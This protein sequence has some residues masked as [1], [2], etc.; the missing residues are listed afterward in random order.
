MRGVPVCLFLHNDPRG[1]R[2]ARSAVERGRL[3]GAL[4]GV[5]TVSGYLRGRLLEGVAAPARAVAV[6]PNCL[7]L[8]A[9]PAAAK[10]DLILFAGRVVADKGA[11]SFVAACG[12]ALPGLPGW[13]AAM[14]G[15]DRFGADSPET[16]WIA[17]LRPKAA[18][19]GVVMEG[20]RPHAEVLAAMARA[21]IVVVPS[22]WEEPFGLTALEAMACGAALVA[23][24]RGGLREVYGEAAVV[25][26]PED[27]AGMA[28]VLVALA[29]DPARRAAL[30]AAGRARAAGFDAAP[31]LARLDELRSDVLAAWPRAPAHPI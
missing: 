21:A 11:D 29:R 13:R 16:A 19:S 25:I 22:R 4:A 20:Y 3:V 12:L 1:M 9:V 26:D 31:T 10:E 14:I 28:A 2:G 24:D 23:S 27:P 18:A 8:G 30:A 6:L 17:S 15:A 5:V 7:D